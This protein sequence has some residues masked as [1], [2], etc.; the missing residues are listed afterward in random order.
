MGKMT[1]SVFIRPIIENVE[2]GGQKKSTISVKNKNL[3]AHESAWRIGDC[4]A[5][6]SRLRFASARTRVLIQLSPHKC[7]TKK[8]GICAER[9][10]QL[11]NPLYDDLKL[12]DELFTE[13]KKDNELEIPIG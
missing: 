3:D 9:K 2:F 7:Q 12:L 10:G 8:S 11:S 6:A 1:E 4:F 13:I 5:K